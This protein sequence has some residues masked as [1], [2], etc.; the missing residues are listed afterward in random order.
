MNKT[1]DMNIW[2][3]KSWTGTTI[4]ILSGWFAKMPTVEQLQYAS[5]CIS[6]LAGFI[7]VFYT[8]HKW[9]QLTKNKQQ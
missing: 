7:T 9:Y 5:L 6:I 8:L 2:D 1:A 4:T 3:A